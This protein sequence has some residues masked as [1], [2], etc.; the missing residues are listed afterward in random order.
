[1]PSFEKVEAVIERK[2]RFISMR[3]TQNGNVDVYFS[4]PIYNPENL[5]VIDPLMLKL[6]LRSESDYKAD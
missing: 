5:T 1:V 3:S 4:E 6:E 2:I